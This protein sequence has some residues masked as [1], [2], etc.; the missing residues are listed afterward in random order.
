MATDNAGAVFF[1]SGTNI[2]THA[3]GAGPFT[4]ASATTAVTATNVGLVAVDEAGNVYYTE[5]TTKKI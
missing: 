2:L 1:S 4:A 5:T 3:A